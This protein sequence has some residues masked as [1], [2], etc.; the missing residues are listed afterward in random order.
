M[1]NSDQTSQEYLLIKCFAYK[2][3]PPFTKLDRT[4]SDLS[5]FSRYSIP[6]DDTQYFTKYDI[7]PFVTSYS[8]EQNIDETT[9]SWSLEL[10][11]L[12]LSYGTINNKVKIKPLD[13]STLTGGLSFSS[14]TDS[15]GLVSVYE[16]NSNTF[17]NNTVS[18]GSSN[19]LNTVDP[20]LAAKERRGLTPGPMTVQG[21][22]PPIISK[23]PG[24]RLSDLIQ[25]YD[26]IS[27][28]LYKSTTP[29][30]NI[31]GSFT[32]DHTLT[33]NPQRIFNYKVTTDISP[34]GLKNPLD[35]ELQNESVLLTK[36][37]N[38]QTLF[39]NEFN[40]FVMKKNIQSSIN[41][42]DR[43]IVSGNGWSRLFGSTRR[44]MKPSLFQNSLY[45]AGQVLGLE[46]VSALE[47]NLAGR[48][49]SQIVRDLFDQVYRID[50]NTTTA[51]VI[52]TQAN[53][54]VSNKNNSTNLSS[55]TQNQ[56]E[57]FSS[58]LG[59]SLSVTPSLASASSLSTTNPI[60][61]GDSFYNI[62]SLIVANGY[63]ANLFNMPQY[64]LSTVMKLRPFAYIDITDKT[65][66]NAFIEGAIAAAAQ[67]AA[68]Q[69]NA[70]F[71]A[72]TVDSKSVK[73]PPEYESEN[74]S[75]DASPKL[76]KVPPDEPH[77][78]TQTTVR[79]V[80]VPVAELERLSYF[81]Y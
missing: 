16:T 37:P 76:H 63:P 64:L 56:S 52:N 30:T 71:T 67:A 81:I 18:G 5:T 22:N 26:F 11:D 32:T 12:A 62:T 13:R 21:S 41:Q 45:Q 69:Q 60:L 47:N 27:V 73:V 33:N 20:I 31:W 68:V 79:G 77:D 48:N 58:P 72:S 74:T 78:A 24:L 4:G 10:Q 2:Y 46:D 38:G 25:E 39:S 15:T 35:P 59:S 50:F 42:V 8:F 66:D 36:M 44:A 7:S 43:V 70:N 51:T 1:P 40:G 65:A 34:F 6:L 75:V 3:T 19:S 55:S 17:D 54:L 23:I 80:S 9:Y 29:L 61:L 14:N 57:F 28:F 53:S 49:I